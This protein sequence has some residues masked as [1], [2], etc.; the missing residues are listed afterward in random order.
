M[1]QLHRNLFAA[2]IHAGGWSEELLPL[3]AWCVAIAGQIANEEKRHVIQRA[4]RAFTGAV[5]GKLQGVKDIV[6]AWSNKRRL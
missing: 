2:E 6:A 1:L 5:E 3:D 4:Y